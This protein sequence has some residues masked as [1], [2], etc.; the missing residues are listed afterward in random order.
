[1]L[2]GCQHRTARAPIPHNCMSVK[3]TDFTKPC[4]TL[5]DGS[6]M[7]DGVRVHVNCIEK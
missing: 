5:K 6:L 7:C 3:I 1:M 4:T 2:V